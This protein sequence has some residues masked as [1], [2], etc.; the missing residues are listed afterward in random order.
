MPGYFENF[1]I[2]RYAN[3]FSRKITSRSVFTEESLKER[4]NFYPYELKGDIRPDLLSYFY[5][6][7]SFYDWSVMI[8]NSVIDPYYDWYLSNQQ[9]VSVIEKKY[10]SLAD[11]TTKIKHWEVNWYGDD[12]TITMSQYNS[13]VTDLSAKVD[14]KKY[15]MPVVGDNNKITGYKRKPLDL[16]I[17][18]NKVIELNTTFTSGNT[19]TQQEK[20]YQ[21]SGSTISA[22]A[23]VE[24]SNSTVTLIKNISGTFSNTLSVT[25]EES[26]STATFTNANL[27]FQTIPS[28]EEGYW[29]SVSFYDYEVSENEKRRTINVI[30]KRYIEE[31][32][33]SLQSV[34]TNE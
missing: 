2:I 25:G 15:W 33:N 28:L 18:T 14:Q 7:S 4:Y 20:I 23:F 34:M 22:S 17:K 5:Y 19:F 26:N 21:T 6:N 3:T 24:S 10:G 30:D 13:L 32:Q 9:L 27:I 11:A 29:R 16:T 31:V 1:P 8:S 12:S